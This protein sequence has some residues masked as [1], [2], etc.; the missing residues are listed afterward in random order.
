M[1]SKTILTP[2]IPKQSGFTKDTP[3]IGCRRDALLMP[4]AVDWSKIDQRPIIISITPLVNPK[5]LEDI[6]G[7]RV[8][9]AGSGCKYLVR[10][11]SRD[12]RFGHAE[13][14]HYLG[15]EP[16]LFTS[17][18]LSLPCVTISITAD[19][20]TGCASRTVHVVNRGRSIGS[21]RSA[22]V[23]FAN[24]RFISEV[25]IS[26]RTSFRYAP[27]LHV[28]L[29]R[30]E[31]GIKCFSYAAIRI[32]FVI[33]FNTAYIT[34]EAFVPFAAVHNR[35]HRWLHNPTRCNYDGQKQG[36]KYFFH[37][38]ISMSPYETTFA[39]KGTSGKPKH[40]GY[41]HSKRKAVS[42]FLQGGGGQFT[43]CNVATLKSKYAIINS[44]LRD[45]VGRSE[46]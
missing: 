15:F 26:A 19:C 40:E 41:S 43:P 45:Q 28:F 23:I 13:Y 35:A 3:F 20:I 11:C 21:C 36:H 29:N 33:I 25:S 12:A 34:T 14:P 22:G 6:F 7:S 5:N 9:A 10:G 44:I 27:S 32:S 37:L 42:H 31:L 4:E 30:V 16:Y 2:G 38:I 46:A 24:R 8:P 17:N 1:A 39:N 18:W